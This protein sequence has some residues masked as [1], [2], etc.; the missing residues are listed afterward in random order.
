MNFKPFFIH[1]FNNNKDITRGIRGVTVYISPSDTGMHDV[2][3]RMAFCQHR[4][5]YCK[6]TGREKIKTNPCV[7]FICNGR[8]VVNRIN[9]EMIRRPSQD[10]N[11]IE[12]WV[13]DWVFKYLI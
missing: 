9:E 4:D 5:M 10:P 7:N 2:Q 11:Q 1:R 13:Y 8:Q 12:W 3:V 6:K